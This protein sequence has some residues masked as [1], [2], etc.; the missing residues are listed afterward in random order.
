[1]VNKH[2]I[3]DKGTLHHS[4]EL[5]EGTEVYQDEDMSTPAIT[6]NYTT[7][8]G[9]QLAIKHG[10]V[11]KVSA[12]EPAEDEDDESIPAEK[13]KMPKKPAEIQNRLLQVKAPPPRTERPVERGKGR[14]GR[15][16]R[17]P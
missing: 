16:R 3:T 11:E 9:Q 2:T 12:T 14:T 13:L 4:G 6:D 5:C 10:K 1:V 8:D 7:A 15:S 17:A